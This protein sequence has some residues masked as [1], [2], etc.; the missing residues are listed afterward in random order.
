[1]KILVKLEEMDWQNARDTAVNMWRQA[2][3]TQ[4]MAEANLRVIDEELKKIWDK[5]PE[6]ER[7]K[8]YADNKKN[9]H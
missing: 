2:Q 7:N 9:L 5:L 6:N 4:R 1:M 3:L 8:R